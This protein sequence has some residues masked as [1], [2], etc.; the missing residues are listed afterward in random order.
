VATLEVGVQ[1]VD[2]A[3]FK[4]VAEVVRVETVKAI[5]AAS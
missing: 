4:L 2:L 1:G 3:V 5:M